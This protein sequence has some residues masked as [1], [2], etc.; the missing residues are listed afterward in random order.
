MKKRKVALIAHDGKK[1]DMLALATEYK[2]SSKWPPLFNSLES[3][4]GQISLHSVC[5]FGIFGFR[6][7]GRH[8]G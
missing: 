4:H 2:A 1:A 3:N 7:I 5:I 8:G 6:L